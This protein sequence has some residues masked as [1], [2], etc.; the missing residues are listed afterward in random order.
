[1]EGIKEFPSNAPGLELLSMIGY[2]ENIIAD[3]SVDLK[4]RFY[5]EKDTTVYITAKELTTHRFYMMKPL[6][7]HLYL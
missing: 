7:L 6:L 2:C 3:S 5:L 1:M 4:I